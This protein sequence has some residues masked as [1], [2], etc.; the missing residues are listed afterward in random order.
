MIKDTNKEAAISR[1]S[2]LQTGDAAFIRRTDGTWTFSRVKKISTEKDTAYFVV[3][4]SGS[5]KSYKVKYWHS[6]IRTCKIPNEQ[7]PPHESPRRRSSNESLYG[8]TSD[9]DLSELGN[10][11]QQPHL[12]EPL[13]EKPSAPPKTFEIH[14]VREYEPTKNR[15]S[16]KDLIKPPPP[17]DLSPVKSA[18]RDS[19][20][21]DYNESYRNKRASIDNSES[22]RETSVAD[23]R[24]TASKSLLRK[25]RFSFHDDGQ[26][27]KG[28]KRSVSFSEEWETRSYVKD[29]VPD[30]ISTKTE[31]ED[32]NFDVNGTISSNRAGKYN[33]RGIEP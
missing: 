29:G 15:F 4:S 12:E 30:D 33:L 19:A 28:M 16:I 14:E 20:A 27:N 26:Y 22:S 23:D 21:N 13:P 31:D 10:M 7:L 5:T 2:K 32:D 6:H 11:L 17:K 3:N 18:N 8:C 25:G 9:S 1:I 24:S